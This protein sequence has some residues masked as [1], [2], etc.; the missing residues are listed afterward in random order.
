[1][2]AADVDAVAGIE[3]RAYPFPWSKGLFS[4][5][6]LAGYKSLLCTLDDAVIGY[7]IMIVAAGE[8]HILNVCIE[9][10][11]Q[12]VGLGYRLMARLLKQAKQ[13]GADTA[14]LEVR[15]SNV[16]AIRLYQ[17]LG[18][19]RVGVRVGY[20]P[21]PTGREDAVVLSCSL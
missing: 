15:P 3:G 9:P 2:S 11:F 21:A 16:G 20:Y 19:Q 8:C 7:G 12:R 13:E 4:D 14:F 1:M 17:R 18:F 10:A 5:C 6:L